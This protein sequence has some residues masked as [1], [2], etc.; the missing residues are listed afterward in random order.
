MPAN[1]PR[2]SV[3]ISIGIYI[4]T[5]CLTAYF[6]LYLFPTEVLSLSYGLPLFICLLHRDRVLLWA[7]VV[8]FAIISGCKMLYLLPDPNPQDSHEFFQWVMH[9]IN[10][11]VIG[12]S[13]HAILNLTEKLHAQNA[14]LEQRVQERTA[15]LQESIAELQRISYALTHDMRAP[16]RALQGFASILDEECKTLDDSHR[17]MLHRIVISASRM[18]KLI[19]DALNYTDTVRQEMKLS[20]VDCAKL[21]KGIVESYPAFQP[22]KIE[23]D[24]TNRFGKRSRT[25]PML[26]LIAEQRHCLRQG[27][28]ATSTH[29]PRGNS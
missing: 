26:F 13:V 21:L 9:V 23:I 28:P 5:V 24:I 11:L 22:E 19:T 15:D 1:N 6:R 17:Q 18:D 2:P 29:H 16:L 4:V 14:N 20:P 27:R 7:L 8:T 10:I 3:A 25:D 12:G